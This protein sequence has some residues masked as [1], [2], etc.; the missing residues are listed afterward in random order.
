MIKDLS[1]WQSVHYS[2]RKIPIILTDP[3]EG[4]VA[5]TSSLVKD[6]GGAIIILRSLNDDK[7]MKH[8]AISE[9]LIPK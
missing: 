3:R 8:W 1:E 5:S 2:T 7:E 4:I 9:D 6:K